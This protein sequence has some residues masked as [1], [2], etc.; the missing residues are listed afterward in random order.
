MLVLGK[1]FQDSLMLAVSLGVNIKMAELYEASV[2]VQGKPFKPSLL[3]ANK[4]G[5]FPRTS[6]THKN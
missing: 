6:L 2:F 1:S 5:D 3:F 4:I